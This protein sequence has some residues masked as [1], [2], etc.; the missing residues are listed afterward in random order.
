MNNTEPIYFDEDEYKEMLKR[1][2]TDIL[3]AELKSIDAKIEEENAKVETNNNMIDRFIDSPGMEHL[4]EMS[5]LGAAE[6]PNK[7]NILKAKRT[8]LLD[9]LS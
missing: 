6:I 2:N 5:V 3:K 4:V 9:L 1:F 7:I 8:I